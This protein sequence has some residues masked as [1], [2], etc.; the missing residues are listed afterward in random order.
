MNAHEQLVL[1]HKAQAGKKEALGE[2]WDII[3][4]RLFGYLVNT[5]GNKALAEDILQSTWLKALE[6]LPT[7]T[8][9]GYPFSAWLFAIARNE[10]KQHWRKNA[11]E[12]PFDMEKHDMAATNGNHGE[13]MVIE[14]V[15]SKLSQDDRELLRLRYIADLSLHDVARVLNINSV[16][17]RV[18]MHRAIAR[19]RN[20]VNSQNI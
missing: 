18:R 19:A 10:C 2:L 16:A 12:V 7:Y 14:Q 3:T 15:L 11:H 13:T 9:R 4:P 5:L 1:V 17:V 20:I 8:D 6:A